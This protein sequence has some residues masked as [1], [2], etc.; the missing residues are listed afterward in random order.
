MQ[1]DTKAMTYTLDVERN[2]F[3]YEAVLRKKTVGL[4]V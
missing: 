3:P 1:G 4:V 2:S